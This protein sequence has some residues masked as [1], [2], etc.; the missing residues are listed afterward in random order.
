MKKLLLNGTALAGLALAISATPAAAEIEL[1]LGGHYSAYGIFASQDDGVGEAAAGANDFD[2]QREGEIYFTGETTL[3]NGLT[4]GV[5]VQLEASQDADQI[6]ESYL[7][8]SGNWGRVNVGS[9]NGAAYLLQVGAPAVDA[10][11]DGIDP[12][13]VAINTGANTISGVT[14]R[15]FNYGMGTDDRADSERL[16]YLSP[17]FSGFQ[18]GAS[19]SPNITEDVGTRAGLPVPGAQEDELQIGARWAG[20]FEGAGIVLGAGWAQA[21]DTTGVVGADDR[22]QWNAGAQVNIAGFTVGAAYFQDNNGV[23]NDGDTTTWT[24]GVNYGFGAYTVGASY[25]ATETEVGAGAGEDELDR[26]LVGGSYT[27]GP[28]LSFNGAVHFYDLEDNAGA[29]ASEN[30]ATVVTLGTTVK[31]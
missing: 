13:Y 1:G 31:F 20:D 28:G 21:D 26:V 3:D 24:A 6:D 7:Y 27:Y 16:T 23:S 9:E 25:L 5:E 15:G 29:A 14:G 4:V 10:N 17:V 11:F 8:F 12:E 22:D 30:D 18:V 19:Y 2:L